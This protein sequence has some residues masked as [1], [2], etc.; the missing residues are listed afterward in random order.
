MRSSCAAAGRPSV[1]WSVGTTRPCAEGAP[2]GGAPPSFVVRGMPSS[3]GLAEST[4]SVGASAA[5]AGNP[6]RTSRQVCACPSRTCPGRRTPG[7]ASRPT[8]TSRR[9]TCRIRSWSSTARLSRSGLDRSTW[10]LTGA[11][12]QDAAHRRAL[13]R[14][15]HEFERGCAAARMACHGATPRLAHRCGTARVR[16]GWVAH[17]PVPVRLAPQK[18]IGLRPCSSP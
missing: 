17:A 9:R 11:V 6:W 4:T 7:L 10:I 14:A 5:T 12:A 2:C 18:P 1:R 13:R 16:A 8:A 3:T 15:T